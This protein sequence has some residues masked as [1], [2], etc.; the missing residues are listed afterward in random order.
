MEN[1]LSYVKRP[2]SGREIKEWIRYHVLNETEYTRIA[3]R[4]TRYLSCSDDRLYVVETT[5]VGT[6]CGER[7]SGF[8][9]VRRFEV[10]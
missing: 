1:I 2:V 6:G 8:P 3:R 7:R 10:F 4:M 9:V 5:S